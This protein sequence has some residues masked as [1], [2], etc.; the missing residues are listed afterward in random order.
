GSLQV[1]TGSA[2]V[3]TEG[4]IPAIRF[5]NLV[6]GIYEVKLNLNI[7]YSN[8][9][10]CFIRIYDGTTGKSS[11]AL[12]TSPAGLFVARFKYDSTQT[13]KTFYLQTISGSLTD[14]CTV[15]LTTYYPDSGFEFWVTRIF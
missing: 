7:A 3:P 15:D 2:L 5:A 9:N 11:T 14:T 10:I 1:V 13:N 12:A 4:K 8:D 6:P